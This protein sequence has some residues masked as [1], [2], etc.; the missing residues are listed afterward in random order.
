MKNRI[1]L[2]LVFGIFLLA[3]LFGSTGCKPPAET[4]TCIPQADKEYIL[5]FN[6]VDELLAGDLADIVSLNDL[7]RQYSGENIVGLGT[8]SREHGGELLF[9]SGK[10]YWADPTNDG[11]VTEIDWT[12]EEL[13]FCAIARVTDKDALVFTG[14]TGDIHEWL[15]KKLVE[16]G[17]PLAAIKI[18]GNFVDV[19]LS[20]ADRLPANSSEQLKST[21]TTV[22]QEQ[23]WQIVG[24]YALNSDDQAIITVPE[25]PAHL[26]GKTVDNSHGGHI[27]KANSIFSEVTIYPV[28]QFILSNRVPASAPAESEK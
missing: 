11:K 25:S 27:K 13:P 12:A 24:F 21:L 17:I 4:G 15:G 20:I 23:E 18:S 14:I 9:M 3:W 16:L 22:S 28:K 7:A 5:V 8:T 6:C 26:H 1:V 19:D 2:G 10:C